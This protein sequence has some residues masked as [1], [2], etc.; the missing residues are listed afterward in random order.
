LTKS[1][2]KPQKGKEGKEVWERNLRKVEG[3]LTIYIEGGDVFARKGSR[4]LHRKRNGGWGSMGKGGKKADCHTYGPQ[5]GGG[6][7]APAG[8]EIKNMMEELSYVSLPL[9]EGT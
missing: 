5:V 4:N 9:V 7:T 8:A 1:T 2:R 6:G 3:A